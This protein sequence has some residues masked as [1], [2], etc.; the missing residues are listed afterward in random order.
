[1]ESKYP[2][3]L[4]NLLAFNF[5]PSPPSL[6]I[7]LYNTNSGLWDTPSSNLGI[8]SDLTWLRH[9]NSGEMCKENCNVSDKY[10]E[11]TAERRL[12]SLFLFFPTCNIFPSCYNNIFTSQFPLQ[13]SLSIFQFSFDHFPISEHLQQA[14]SDLHWG[15]YGHFLEIW[16]ERYM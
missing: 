12:C 1:M 5:F 3:P 9:S 4:G 14:T 11:E 13:F 8:S 6:T 2:I 16:V 7:S 15:D 10:N